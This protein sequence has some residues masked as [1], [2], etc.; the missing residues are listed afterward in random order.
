[1][2]RIKGLF[3]IERRQKILEIIK[4][5]GRIRVCDI[6]RIFLVGYEVA[7]KDLAILE[8]DNLIKRVHGGAVTLNSDN[9]DYPMYRHALSNFFAEKNI[10]NGN[11][12]FDH[13]LLE[14]LTD[15]FVFGDNNYYTNSLV[16]ANKIT[17]NNRSVRLVGNEY[18]K[19]CCTYKSPCNFDNFDLSCI[20]ILYDNKKDTFW[21]DLKSKFDFFSELIS[22]S[23][24][25]LLIAELRD[26]KEN[27]SETTFIIP[28]QNVVE[29]FPCGY[30]SG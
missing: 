9:I 19:D 21:I 10:Y 22:N 4:K 20:G 5:E 26:I 16:I 7:K 6:Q 3:P 30:Y 23:N 27:D 13:S 18:S 17:S 1:M 28:V 2:E 24:H 25:V 14:I 8:T 11:V 15:N 12:F 29:I